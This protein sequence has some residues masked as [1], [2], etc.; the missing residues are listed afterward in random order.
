MSGNIQT[1]LEANYS[2]SSVDEKKRGTRGRKPNQGAITFYRW[3][4]IKINISTGAMGMAD[5]NNRRECLGDAEL[6]GADPGW[7]RTVDAQEDESWKGG[8]TRYVKH[9]LMKDPYSSHL[10]HLEWKRENVIILLMRS[11]PVY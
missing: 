11:V 2:E 7:G 6:S 8:N 10:Y 9:L 5:S 3:Q 1:T 4:M